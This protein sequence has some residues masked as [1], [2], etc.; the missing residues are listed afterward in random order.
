MIERVTWSSLATAPPLCACMLEDEMQPA[1][2]MGMFGAADFSAMIRKT[3]AKL[4]DEDG[5]CV[6]HGKMER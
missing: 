4:Y 6:T 2:E 3:F 5:G 1:I